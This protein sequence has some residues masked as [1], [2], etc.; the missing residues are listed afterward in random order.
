MFSKILVNLLSR[1]GHECNDSDGA[2]DFNDYYEGRHADYDG[3]GGD[4]SD[5]VTGSN[6]GGG[7]NPIDRG[8]I[9]SWK[10]KCKA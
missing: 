9:H 1:K 4:H 2:G 7:N 5:N 3:H 8:M 10:F 6:T